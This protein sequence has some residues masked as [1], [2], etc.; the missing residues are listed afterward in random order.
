MENVGIICGP[1]EYVY[2]GPLVYYMAIWYFSGYLVYIS[3]VLVY[4]ITKNLA[5]L[6]G[7]PQN[8]HFQ[9]VLIF[10]FLAIVLDEKVI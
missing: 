5:A 7:R 10:L 9:I 1:L 3:P 4:C 8:I 2:Y 6:L